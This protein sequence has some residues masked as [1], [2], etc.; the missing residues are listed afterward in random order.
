MSYI[1]QVQDSMVK[2][3]PY[4]VEEKDL[5]TWE[6]ADRWLRHFRAKYPRQEGYKVR[7]L[8]HNPALHTTIVKI[9]A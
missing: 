3:K 6:A 8:Y 2:T 4:F 9:S 5:D 1:V 7:V